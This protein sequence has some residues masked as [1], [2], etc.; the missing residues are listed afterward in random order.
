MLRRKNSTKLGRFALKRKEEDC[1][2]N[3]ITYSDQPVEKFAA[4]WGVEEHNL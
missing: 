1:I 4:F 3:G 2:E